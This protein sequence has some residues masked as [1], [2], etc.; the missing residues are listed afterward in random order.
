MTTIAKNIFTCWGR[1]IFTVTLIWL[2]IKPIQNTLTKND[3]VFH[4]LLFICF[5]VFVIIMASFLFVGLLLKPITLS[6]SPSEGQ[7]FTHSIL[8]GN[9]KYSV[10]D[11]EGFSKTKLWTR[12]KDYPGIL[13]Y[14]KDN[15]K[16]ELNEFNLQSLKPFVKFLNEKHINY[17]GEET[18]WFPFRPIHYRFDK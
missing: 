6:F 15:S 4:L 14:C 13:L 7:L 16:I 5:L 9:R 3:D 2:F 11:L 12:S 18:S 17:F 8:L 10:N 1:I